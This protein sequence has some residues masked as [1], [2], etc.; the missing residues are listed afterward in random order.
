MRASGVRAT[1]AAAAVDL[2]LNDP[3]DHVP[4]REILPGRGEIGAE[5]EQLVLDSA[6]LRARLMIFDMEQGDSDRRIGFV[7]VAD[8]LASRMRLGNA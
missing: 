7:D 2:V 4:G 3:Q 5:V 1:S 6:E 8:R